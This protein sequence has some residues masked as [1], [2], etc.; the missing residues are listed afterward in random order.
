MCNALSN[1]LIRLLDSPGNVC[2]HNFLS[3]S[4]PDG[5]SVWEYFF[6]VKLFRTS[7]TI[8]GTEMS[9]NLRGDQATVP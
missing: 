7:K 6:S 4:L 2:L 1:Y 5:D 3:F 8:D 9:Y